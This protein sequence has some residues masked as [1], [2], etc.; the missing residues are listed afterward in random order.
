MNKPVNLDLHD[1]YKS[2]WM[3]SDEIN[4]FSPLFSTLKTDAQSKNYNN[5]DQLMANGSDRFRNLCLLYM[6]GFG[7]IKSF[8]YFLDIYTNYCDIRYDND[9]FFRCAVASGAYGMAT[10][11]IEKGAD[12][13][14]NGNYAICTVSRN[15]YNY[16]YVFLQKL[17]DCGV[18]VNAKNGLP[19]TVAIKWNITKNIILLIKNGADPTIND[20]HPI[21]ELCKHPARYENTLA[22]KCLLDNNADP[23]AQNGTPLKNCIR[24]K[25]WVEMLLNHGASVNYLNEYDLCNVIFSKNLHIA[26]LL[27]SHGVDFGILNNKQCLE[28]ENNLTEMENLVELLGSIG[29]DFKSLALILMSALPKLSL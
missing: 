26:K 8:G 24:H 19:L 13:C 27:Q 23:N 11:L 20:N 15:S 1:F 14:A 29:V 5:I 7:D 9:L 12:V 4:K 18:D 28:D 16:N 21:C 6:I 22:L 2:G 10:I 17:I 3:T 25:D